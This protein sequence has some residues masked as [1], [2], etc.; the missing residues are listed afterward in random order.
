VIVSKGMTKL[1]SATR[2]TGL[3]LAGVTVALALAATPGAALAKRHRAANYGAGTGS[4]NSLAAPIGIPAAACGSSFATCCTITASGV[5]TM[6]A[7]F[8]ATSGTGTCIAI[9]N[10]SADITNVVVNLGGFTIT[11]SA[12]NTGKGTGIGVSGPSSGGFNGNSTGVFIEG[13]NGGVSGFATGVSANSSAGGFS[14][15]DPYVTI[16]GV[17]AGAN[18]G[19]GFL[20][21]GTNVQA[22][23]IAGTSNK[24]GA[25]ISGCLNCGLNFVDAE[26]NSQYGVWIFNST[27]SAV[28][29]VFTLANGV[30]GIYA[31]CNATTPGNTCSSNTGDNNQI[32]NS[33]SDTNPN[34]TAGL[35]IYLDNGETNTS[36]TNNSASG[37]KF[38][39]FDKNGTCG[40]NHW[41]GNVFT[42]SS[43]SCVH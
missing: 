25:E 20:I 39:G 14:G 36:V 22:S 29:S 18:S 4:A 5:Y 19:A 7:S 6:S 26:S 38:D 32:F 23:N 3:A 16:E 34:A 12:G 35:G 33:I 17:N 21:T 1:I 13:L 15:T 24:I 2:I 27:E 9:G 40:S 8:T 28:N 11:Q 43:P 42:A 10:G 37:D 31:G 41:F 30:A